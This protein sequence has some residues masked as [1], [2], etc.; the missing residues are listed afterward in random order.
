MADRGLCAVC[1]GNYAVA[2]DGT[3]YKH[4]S[5]SEQPC[6]GSDQPI[7]AL[8]D[9][10]VYLVY[11]GE[12]KDYRFVVIGPVDKTVEHAE[13]YV[14]TADGQA[15]PLLGTPTSSDPAEI[16]AL[17]PEGQGIPV[18]AEPAPEE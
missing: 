18:P 11:G 12:V 4:D 10:A 16:N 8:V 15:V 2:K 7:S 14:I 1:G 6:S 13:E 9:D 17:L 3:P 5:E